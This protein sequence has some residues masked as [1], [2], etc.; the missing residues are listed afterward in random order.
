MLT[1]STLQDDF[2][3]QLA[4]R[5]AVRTVANLEKAGHDS[6]YT[7]DGLERSLLTQIND[8]AHYDTIVNL[9]YANRLSFCSDLLALPSANRAF[10]VHF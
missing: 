7:V 4:R 2:A 9:E 3:A 6:E 1:L 8:D 5:L 10:F